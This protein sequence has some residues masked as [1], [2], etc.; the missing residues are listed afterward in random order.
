MTLFGSILPFRFHN[1]HHMPRLQVFG[2]VAE[3]LDDGELR[4]LERASVE[5]A[6][7]LFDVCFGDATIVDQR[8][9]R[10]KSRYLFPIH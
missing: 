10:E 9:L 6:P 7:P 5:D 1:G 3:V 2:R 8:R 4:F